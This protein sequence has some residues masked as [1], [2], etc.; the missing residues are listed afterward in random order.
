MT[1]ASL[2][3]VN[4]VDGRNLTLSGTATLAGAG[5]GSPA[6]VTTPVTPVRV[7]SATGNTGSSAA[8]TIPVTVSATT[9]GNTLVAVVSTRGTAVNQVSSISGGGVWT[10]A[11][12]AANA[13]GTT[14]EI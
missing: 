9:V 5:V 6:L 11:A 2:T 14:T 4:N 8:T 7:Q 13:N 10:R 1:A 3:M 12:Q